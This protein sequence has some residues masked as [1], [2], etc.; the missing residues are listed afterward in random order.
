MAG[1]TDLNTIWRNIREID[2]QNFKNEALREMRIALVGEPG[3]GRHTLADNLR[4]DP[5]R[6]EMQTQT[7]ILILDLLEARQ[8]FNADLT[9]IV[10]DARRQEFA[11]E[12]SLTAL[13][14]NQGKKVVI[15]HNQFEPPSPGDVRLV[16]PASRQ[17]AGSVT[18]THFL[19]QKFVPVI[20]EM[21]PDRLLGLGR[22]FP[23]FRVPI[24]HHL[25]NE[26]CFAN[27]T[28]ALGTGLAEVVTVLNLP[29]T[30]ADMIVLTKS[31]A[32][33][34]Y[35]LGLVFGF[36][37]QWRDYLA[38]FGSVI[39]GGF[40][41]RQV[42]RSLVGLIPVLGIVPKIAVSYSGTFVVGHT[43]LQWYLT[44][45]HLSAQQ[46]KALT[47]QAF[48]RGQ[49]TAR[50][51]TMKMRRPRL[52]GGKKKSKK[53]SLPAL[54]SA[55]ELAALEGGSVEGAVPPPA[56]TKLSKKRFGWGK[57]DTSGSA[58]AKAQ[59]PARASRKKPA[60]KGKEV[61]QEESKL[62]QQCGRANSVDA[63]YCQYCGTPFE[64]S[65][66]TL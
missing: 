43:I 31:Q 29:L 44:G 2:L 47:V 51:I 33:L 60:R 3:S 48:Q 35:K 52:E 23:L 56:T 6:P 24:A 40:I 49:D 5:S 57:K 50:R 66:E 19:Q 12:M 16:W 13:W 38:E 15:F 36:S 55:G 8:P 9:L 39:G 14:N 62:S 45:R 61:I 26:T 10:V 20:M 1:I 22:Q 58:V 27:T 4:R 46:M 17:V 30:V 21:M 7:P 11:A 34:V 28:Y 32:F 64:S 63:N 37:L 53:K 54:D 41:W 42:A 59:K 25:I 18:D 65:I